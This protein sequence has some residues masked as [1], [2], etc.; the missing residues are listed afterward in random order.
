MN[1]FAQGRH[2]PSKNCIT[3]SQRRQKVETTLA[4]ERSGLACLNRD[5]GQ[6]FTSIGSKELGKMLERRRPH[7]QKL[8]K[9]YT[10]LWY[11]QSWFRTILFFTLKLLWFP[12]VWCFFL[13]VKVGNNKTAGLLSISQTFTNLHIHIRQ[14]LRSVFKVDTLFPEAWAAKNTLLSVFVSIL[15]NWCLEKPPFIISNKKDAKR[16]LLQDK[17]RIHSVD[18]LVDRVEGISVHLQKLLGEPRF[19]FE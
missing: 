6:V 8:L 10:L 18:V 4:N 16:W 9:T 13:K 19:L 12:L 17:F 5:L 7:N 2:D 3:E 14:L 11:A 1:M 15:L